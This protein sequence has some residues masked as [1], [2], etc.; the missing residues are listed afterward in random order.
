MEN[1]SQRG[2]CKSQ[3][4][5]LVSEERNNTDEL[6]SQKRRHINETS[7][8]EEREEIGDTPAVESSPEIS[9]TKQ[10]KSKHR[11]KRG[12]SAMRQSASA[13]NNAIET[14]CPAY[15]WD[16][17][18]HGKN[19]TVLQELPNT[20]R[21]KIASQ[22]TDGVRGVRGFSSGCHVFEISFG[23]HEL[24]SHCGVGM[25]KDDSALQAQGYKHLFGMND[26]SW[27][28]DL[29]TGSLLHR[30]L[31]VGF[32]PI[33]VDSK[34]LT[35]RLIIDRDSGTLSID[36]GDGQRHLAFSGMNAD[37]TENKVE[38]YPAVSL[39]YGQ[40]EVT[41]ALLV[42]QTASDD[43]A[44]DVVTQIT[45][46]SVL[47]ESPSLVQLEG[48]YCETSVEKMSQPPEDILTHDV[49][50]HEEC[51]VKLERR[52]AQP[53]HCVQLQPLDSIY[54]QRLIN[55][56]QIGVSPTTDTSVVLQTTAIKNNVSRP[57][58]PDLEA[59]D[60]CEDEDCLELAEMDEEDRY[61]LQM[62]HGWDST[63]RGG[64][65][66]NYPGLPYICVPSRK[67]NER[68]QAVRCRQGF[69][70]GKHRWLIRDLKLFT[71]AV[72]VEDLSTT[73][74]DLII[75]AVSEEH[76]T[77]NYGYSMKNIGEHA[78][79]W[80][81]STSQTWHGKQ[82]HVQN[83]EPDK[84]DSERM[85]APVEVE[86]CLDVR[87][88]TMTLHRGN[89]HL[90]TIA[91]MEGREFF[92]CIWFYR[93][94]VF[95]VKIRYLVGPTVYTQER[96]QAVRSLHRY[97]RDDFL[98]TKHINFQTSLSSHSMLA[99]DR[100]IYK[101]G[102]RSEN[103][104]LESKN[105]LFVRPDLPDVQWALAKNTL[106][107]GRHDIDFCCDHPDKL[108]VGLVLVRADIDP[109]ENGSDDE[110]TKSL[111]ALGQD[112]TSWGWDIGEKTL[113]HAGTLLGRFP[114]DMKGAI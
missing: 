72:A 4:I 68:V 15:G 54:E 24:G 14:S 45:K 76:R 85:K 103:V 89:E 2:V 60:S 66:Q 65:L 81:P 70:R 23:D 102:R 31:L 39:V 62:S 34:P 3:E 108:V 107:D 92:P 69:R 26:K 42:A 50:A 16:V 83:G 53:T 100:S 46:D 106:C 77:F 105:H 19:I 63:K 43:I 17:D 61:L 87:R 80:Q 20:A 74:N 56:I 67:F 111:A 5:L 38:L 48:Q 95:P 82:A 73:H 93:K 30:G 78:W 13:K 6:S 40:A 99:L 112:A 49:S 25:C 101:W 22:S 59:G 71:P 10:R 84:S 33:N 98:T 11:K 75:G 51:L 32:L 12:N 29:P 27:A 86:V 57:F 113:H 35:I 94:A 79:G 41:I 9:K 37:E 7:P 104:H 1:G 36:R 64:L 55:S 44:Y 21:R 52:A 96:L 109:S 88:A 91:G 47:E 114:P 8:Q 18:N 97:L 28:W 58:S 90:A 110:S